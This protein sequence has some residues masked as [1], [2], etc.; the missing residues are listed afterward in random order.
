MR[1]PAS[2]I[3]MSL[4]TAVPFGLAIRDTARHHDNAADDEV[5]FDGTATARRERVADMK[6][7]EEQEAKD[8]A[9][10]AERRA[11]VVKRFHEMY[12]AQPASLGSLFDG[13]K[14]GEHAT[15]VL[16]EAGLPDAE[17][18]SLAADGAVFGELAGQERN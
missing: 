10:A 8:K 6:A 5:D 16:H 2:V 14:L 3:V 4:V 9:E 12:G 13:I 7:Y 15:E 18:A 17:I 1:I 11:L